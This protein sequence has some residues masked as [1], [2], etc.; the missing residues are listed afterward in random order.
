MI[1]EAVSQNIN[2]QVF[3][4][5][6][7]SIRWKKHR[8][9]FENEHLMFPLKECMWTAW[10]QR[11][12]TWMDFEMNDKFSKNAKFCYIFKIHQMDL[13]IILK[14]RIN[15]INSVDALK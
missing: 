1:K 13:K 9:P 15:V 8:S 2:F 14:A 4:N 3:I 6:D 5:P 10:F 7:G 12:N 11:K